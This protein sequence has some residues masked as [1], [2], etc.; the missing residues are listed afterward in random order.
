MNTANCFST[1]QINEGMFHTLIF[2]NMSFVYQ[3]L[4]KSLTLTIITND[5][6]L[7]SKANYTQ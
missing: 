7:K 1:H 2:V 4:F 5:N 3:P 6:Y